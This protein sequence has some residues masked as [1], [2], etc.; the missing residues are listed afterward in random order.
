MY[1]QEAETLKFRHR[2][3]FGKM[4]Y[5]YIVLFIFSI[6][7]TVVLF[8]ADIAEQLLGLLSLF[9]ASLF[10]SLMFNIHGVEIDL[11]RFIIITYKKVLWFRISKRYDLTDFK[12]ITITQDI[13]KV[14]TTR[15]ANH[16]SDS[17]YYYYLNLVSQIRN[18]TI[19]LD[20]SEDYIDIADASVALS[21]QLNMNVYDGVSNI[22]NIIR[23]H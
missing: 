12:T 19:I 7:F 18:Q 2:S 21:I 10:L 5:V 1:K 6:V 9:L 3:L 4:S 22:A 20:E 16:I 15:Y 13:V 8:Q 11:N 23:N 17:Y 14:K